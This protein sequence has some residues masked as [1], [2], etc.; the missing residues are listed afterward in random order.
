MDY[1]Q[2]SDLSDQT[3]VKLLSAERVDSGRI[4]VELT[5]TTRDL[6]RLQRRRDELIDE[7]LEHEIVAAYAHVTGRDVLALWFSATELMRGK[8]AGDPSDDPG[9]NHDSPPAPDEPGAL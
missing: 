4:L 6:G 8:A 7:G 1:E 2:P 5:C 9:K 3:P